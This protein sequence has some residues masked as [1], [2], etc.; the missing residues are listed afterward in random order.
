MEQRVLAADDAHVFFTWLEHCSTVPKHKCGSL[1]LIGI[2]GL[3][4][5]SLC[6]EQTGRMKDA[7]KSN[8]DLTSTQID[9]ITH[10]GGSVALCSPR[11]PPPP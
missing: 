2:A 8:T 4:D 6:G 5:M 9:A 1:Q 3:E 7:L 11:P 10:T